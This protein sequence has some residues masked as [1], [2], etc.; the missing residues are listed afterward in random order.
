MKLNSDNLNINLRHIRAL[1]AVADEGSFNAAAMKLGVVPSALSDLIRQLEASIGSALFDRSS[2]PPIMTPLAR[3]FLDEVEPLLVGMDKAITRMRQT[4]G[5][6]LGS[7]SIGASPS[8][9]TELLAPELA[10]FLADRPMVRCLL[11]DDV[12]ETLAQMV[13]AGQLDMAVAG[14]A[15]HSPDLRQSEIMR[16]EFGLACR[17]DDKLAKRG[18]RLEDL[19]HRVLIGLTANSGSHQLLK[20]S[21]VPQELLATRINAHSTVAQLCMIRAG[22]GIALLPRNAVNLFNDPA[23]RFV[24]I[25]DLRLSR[26]VYLLEPAKRPLSALADAFSR[27]LKSH[28]G[29][30]SGASEEAP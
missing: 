22:M 2:R 27:Q 13:A 5:L 10:A 6:E 9:I 11:H 16:D 4:A 29:L 25:K 8:A 12:A 7:I 14:R 21:K 18:V 24:H 23:L 20:R 30:Q 1:Q 3:A 19:R 15:F 28:I 17:S 26:R